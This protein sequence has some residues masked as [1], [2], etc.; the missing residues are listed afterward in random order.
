MTGP[1]S[2]VARPVTLEF[3]DDLQAAALLPSKRGM[4]SVQA[5]IGDVVWATSLVT[6]W[7]AS[8]GPRS[9]TLAGL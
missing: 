4:I 7:P 9:W 8:G 1:V 2:G 6:V 5:R 3:R